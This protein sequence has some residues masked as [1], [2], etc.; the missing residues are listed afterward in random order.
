MNSKT[1]RPYSRHPPRNDHRPLF[2]TFEKDRRHPVMRYLTTREAKPRTRYSR[3]IL[4]TMVYGPS[5]A[6]SEKT[7]PM[8]VCQGPCFGH[9]KKPTHTGSVLSEIISCGSCA[10]ADGLNVD[11]ANQPLA[12]S[13]SESSSS[14][15]E[16][17]SSGNLNAYIRSVRM[18]KLA[19]TEMEQEPRHQLEKVQ[20]GHHPNSG[21]PHRP[22]RDR[23]GCWF[24]S[25]PP[26]SS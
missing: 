9:P 23:N 11:D 13:S 1:S 17:K 3:R 10:A 25:S 18:R 22:P 20:P 8:V 4:P 14:E 6:S 19:M 24:L 21:L 15:D 5:L 7:H 12:S 2:R 26:H 16:P